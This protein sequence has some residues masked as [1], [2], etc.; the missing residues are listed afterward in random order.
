M[1]GFSFT[2]RPQLIEA[3]ALLC[4]GASFQSDVNPETGEYDFE[5]V[6]FHHTAE[7]YTPPTKEVVM[8]YLEKIQLEWDEKVKYSVLRQYAYPAVEELADAVYWQSQGDNTKM[9][10]YLAKVELVK[11][12]F[13]KN[14]PT[15]PWRG[16]AKGTVVGAFP[17]ADI[18][19]NPK[20][21][22]PDEEHLAPYIAPTVPGIDPT[23][24]LPA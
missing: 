7:E 8:A 18:M 24:D 10:E 17:G 14:D 6:T 13:P 21:S 23:D 11:T 15:L 4:T 9:E 3:L 22:L 5:H 19:Q 12:T 1:A 20:I 16:S 2:S